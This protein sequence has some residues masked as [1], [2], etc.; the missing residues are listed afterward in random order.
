MNKRRQF[1]RNDRYRAGEA[2]RPTETKKPTHIARIWLQFDKTHN[3]EPE[4]MRCLCRWEVDGGNQ[5]MSR[6]DRETDDER[7]VCEERDAGHNPTA[8][9]PRSCAY[10]YTHCV[11]LP[12]K[13]SLKASTHQTRSACRPAAPPSPYQSPPRAPFAA[14]V[15]QHQATRAGRARERGRRAKRA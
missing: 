3:P 11:S 13:K 4:K 7:D 8:K 2:T 1:E 12:P 15:T 5:V 10:M 9:S 14:R 6:E